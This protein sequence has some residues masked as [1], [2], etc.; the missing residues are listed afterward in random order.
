MRRFLIIILLLLLIPWLG[1]GQKS[2]MFIVDSIPIYNQPNTKLN[3][4]KK[5]NVYSIQIIA[6][7]D[8]LRQMGY[9]QVD[10]A[11]FIITNA[12]INRPESI[13]KIP[14]VNQ[15]ELK[16]NQW[17]LMNEDSAYTGPFINYYLSGDKLGEGQFK[18]GK[19][20][21]KRTMY[22]E[23][24]KVKLIRQY[25]DGFE[26]GLDQEYFEDGTL[27]QTGNF[28]TGKEDGKWERPKLARAFDA[29]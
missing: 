9:S 18:N 20:D 19:L 11:I 24:G 6:N 1:H 14:S 21:G 16:N 10:T 23:N 7:S 25:V 29:L 12:Y 8:S 27:K 28:I 2:S 17:F 4:L 26:N 3:N 5:E 15:M 22:F 13:R